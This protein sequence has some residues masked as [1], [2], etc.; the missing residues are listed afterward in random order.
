MNSPARYLIA[1]LA[2]LL[3]ACAEKA[4]EDS[5]FALAP[6]NLTGDGSAEVMS[7]SGELLYEIEPE[8]GQRVVAADIHP[9]ESSV[10]LVT[11]GVV[12]AEDIE[13]VRLR[14]SRARGC[15][16]V[17]VNLRSPQASKVMVSGG[18]IDSP[19]WDPVGERLAVLVDN[20]VRVLSRGSDEPLSAEELSVGFEI[21]P[22]DRFRPYLRWSTDGQ[23]VYLFDTS[24][25]TDPP[26]APN[27]SGRIGRFDPG[28]GSLEWLQ[29]RRIPKFL[30]NKYQYD[31]S[32]KEKRADGVNVLHRAKNYLPDDAPT[33]ALFGSAANP[34]FAPSFAADRRSYYYVTREEGFF[35]NE[36]IEGS[37]ADGRHVFRVKTLWWQLYY[38]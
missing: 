22:G 10:A 24:D 23:V 4:P 28:D 20:E 3:V 29:G 38:E 9:G 17:D 7:A 18:L 16:L 32:W 35:A 36:W 27:R 37:S 34:V 30:A 12:E 25:P 1:T 11:C 33:R 13:P 19:M 6:E 8:E 14:L 2:V 21:D 15:H 31:E 26:D 5:V